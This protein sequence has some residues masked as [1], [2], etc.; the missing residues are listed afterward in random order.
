MSF[1]SRL[2]RIFST[3]IN[4]ALDSVENKEAAL[5]QIVKDMQSEYR[6]TK[7]FLA[8]AIVHHKKLQ[9]DAIKHKQAADNYYRKA[10]AILTDD[11]ESNDYLA[12]EALARKKDE[13]AV[14]DQYAKA[15]KQ[16]ELQVGK[17][18]KNI[19]QMLKKIQS[20][21]RKKSVLLAKKQMA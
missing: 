1:W 14:A 7:G 4:S 13:D 21:K 2:K 20:S 12:R 5:E 10:R 18:K 16:Q 3:N 11:D 19:E 6:K 9:R 17:L 8:E 15:A